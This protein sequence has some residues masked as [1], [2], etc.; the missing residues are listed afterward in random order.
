MRALSMC[1]LRSLWFKRAYS[2]S[3]FDCDSEGVISVDELKFILSSL[4]VRVSNQEIEEMIKAGDL[5][6]D[7]KIDFMEFRKMIGQ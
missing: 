2:T 5:D 3:R 6:G 7:G 4:P 1:L